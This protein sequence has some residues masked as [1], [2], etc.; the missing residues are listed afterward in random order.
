MGAL[1]S[2]GVIIHWNGTAVGEVISVGGPSGSA[3]VINV[4]HLGST[5]AEKLM[6]AIDE[7][8]VTLEVNFDPTDTAQIGLKDDRASR[9]K[10]TVK[11]YLTDSSG[12]ILQFDAYCTGL[13][14][15]AAVNTQVKGTMTLEI[16]GLVNK[17]PR[18]TIFTAYNSG[19]GVL[20]LDLTDDTFA[21]ALNSENTGNWSWGYDGSGLVI[22]TVVRTSDTRATLTYTT[23]G[24]IAGSYTMT[25]QALAAALTGSYDS[26]IL[27]VAITI[28]A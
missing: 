14:A 22:N 9:T 12:T 1:E 27:D 5:A 15:A 7:G 25:V 19:T 18:L 10:R 23:G 2:Q 4:T 13:T 16:D 20:V 26:G 3:P 24:G 8:Q 28:P 17:S 11:L 21:A 6:G